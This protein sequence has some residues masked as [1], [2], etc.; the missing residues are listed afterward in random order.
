[1]AEEKYV[2]RLHLRDA[3]EDCA[4][5]D[6]AGGIV[7]PF[8]PVIVKTDERELDFGTWDA[9]KGHGTS[10][11]ARRSRLGEASILPAR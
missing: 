10:F 5:E 4:A 3:I 2:R 8:L 7:G 11:G 1:V 9:V 6:A